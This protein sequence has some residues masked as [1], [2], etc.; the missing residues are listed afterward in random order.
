[1]FTCSG[2]IYCYLYTLQC[3]HIASLHIA[4]SDPFLRNVRSNIYK[5]RSVPHRSQLQFTNKITDT[6]SIIIVPDQCI[7]I[8]L[9]SGP[10]RIDNSLVLRFRCR[11]DLQLHRSN[12]DDQSAMS[13]L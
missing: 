3:V 9:H 4:N 8:A 7:N 1:M 11:A 13:N 10:T 5:M 12:G 2:F 6:V